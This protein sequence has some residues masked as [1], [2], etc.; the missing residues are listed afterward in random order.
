MSWVYIYWVTHYYVEEPSA[1]N[2]LFP[3]F[4]YLYYISQYNFKFWLLIN[5][6][7]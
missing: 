5:F 7:L 3:K 1:I 2:I 4:A 6:Y